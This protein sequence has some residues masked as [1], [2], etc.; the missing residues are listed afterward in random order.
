MRTGTSCPFAVLLLDLDRFEPIND[1]P[2]LTSAPP[3]NRSDVVMEATSASSGV[4]ILE[5]AEEWYAT[6]LGM[7]GAAHAFMQRHFKSP[8]SV[9]AQITLGRAR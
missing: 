4:G 3:P 5:Q 2:R 9:P 8:Q 1:F 6:P 7:T